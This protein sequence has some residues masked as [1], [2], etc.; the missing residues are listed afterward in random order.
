MFFPKGTYKITTSINLTNL[1]GYVL[2]ASAA[3]IVYSGGD[4]AFRLTHVTNSDF[5]FGTIT[6]SAGGCVGLFASSNS[7]YCQYVNIEFLQFSAVSTG[8]C[9]YADNTGAGWINEIRIA[10]GRFYSGA[11]G[12]YIHHNGTNGIS[13]WVF[14]KVGIEGVT[15]GIYMH[16]DS[17][18][19]AASKKISYISV[20]EARYA[21]ATTF[22]K[23]S[24]QV[25]NVMI[26]DTYG[27]NADK[28]DVTSD[29]TNWTL[30]QSDGGAHM[31]NGGWTKYGANMWMNVSSAF[32]FDTTKVTSSTG[33]RAYYNPFT[34]QIMLGGNL[35]VALTS[36]NNDIATI[37]TYTAYDAYYV[38]LPF[39]IEGKYCGSHIT[40]RS[41]I[42]ISMTE[43]FTGNMICGG[44][45]YVA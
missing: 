39:F 20:I 7:T 42:R 25:W 14:D 13:H 11:N 31:Y 33:F 8:N 43:A 24:G 6:A 35:T 9:I 29:A 36:G 18:A 26:V 45:W 41:K 17:V 28:F 40:G 10:K 27:I 44:S 16:T 3:D 19:A 22:I 38:G 5:Y 1:D 2:D 4:Y 30:Y 23:T 15:N 12:C 21:E 34:K 37:S 32:T